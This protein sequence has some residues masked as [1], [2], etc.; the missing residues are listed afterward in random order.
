MGFLEP[1]DYM[2]VMNLPAFQ[3]IP[4]QCIELSDDELRALKS[5]GCKT[6]INYLYWARGW[7]D[8]DRYVAQAERVGM[9]CVL[10][11]PMGPRPGLPENCYARSKGDGVIS[12]V[13]SIW[14]D[15][16]K[17]FLI[18]H[19]AE[20][21]ERYPDALI[22][23][24]DYL[25]GE[26]VLHNVPSFYDR[27]A[28]ASY[29]DIYPD[30]NP[31]IATS[32]TVEWL[33]DSVVKHFLAV[34]RELFHQGSIWNALQWCIAQQS[35]ANGNFAQEDVLRAERKAWPDAEIVLLQYT[36]FAHNEPYPSLVNKWMTDFNLKVIVEAQYCEGLERTAP[37]A[38]ERGFHGQIVCPLHPWAGVERVGQLELAQIAAA[39]RLWEKARAS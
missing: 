30:T 12:S 24:H 17:G 10:A 37:V 32:E 23:Y 20:A 36:H 26:S 28:L 39:H 38:I 11:T 21:M 33:R 22:V 9:K 35:M 8:A 19:L 7:Q 34:D 27:A 18:E 5:V 6:V 1:D 16:A 25:G 31:D 13:M 29:H 2:V 15:E 14:S 3:R 4:G